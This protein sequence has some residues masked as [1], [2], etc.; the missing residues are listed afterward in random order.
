MDD[1]ESGIKLHR[2]GGRRRTK[3]T[4]KIGVSRATSDWLDLALHSEE[5]GED[6]SP[7]RSHHKGKRSSSKVR[8]GSTIFR[9]VDPHA[10]GQ[11][12]KGS[13]VNRYQAALRRYA[14][15]FKV[16]NGRAPN[17]DED[18]RPVRRTRTLV[19]DSGA[20]AA[21]PEASSSA[22]PHGKTVAAKWLSSSMLVASSDESPDSPVASKAAPKTNAVTAFQRVAQPNNSARKVSN[23]QLN[24]L[25]S[26][27]EARDEAQKAERKPASARDRIRNW[28]EQPAVEMGIIGVV[29]AYG[30]FV[31]VDIAVGK[32]ALGW[33]RDVGALIV[34]GFFLS[35]F[36]IELAVKVVV[37]GPASYC[38]SAL[39]VVD[40]FAIVLCATLYLLGDLL[41]VFGSSGDDDEEDGN[42]LGAFLVL[43]RVVRVFRLAAVMLRTLNASQSVGQKGGQRSASAGRRGSFQHR[44]TGD[45]LVAELE[46]EL[47][48]YRGTRGARAWEQHRREQAQIRFSPSKGLT[49]KAKSFFEQAPPKL[50][51]LLTSDFS[52]L[53]ELFKAL[54]QDGDGMLLA[55]E[56][57]PGLIQLGLSEET[58][59]ALFDAL[60][61]SNDGE[62][63]VAELFRAGA[64]LRTR[65]APSDNIT[66]Q[67]RNADPRSSPPVL[68]QQRSATASIALR[69]KHAAKRGF[70]GCEQKLRTGAKWWLHERWTESSEQSVAWNSQGGTFSEIDR[71]NDELTLRMPL[72]YDFEPGKVSLFEQFDGSGALLETR[73]E[74][75]LKLID[76]TQADV[77]NMI[78]KLIEIESAQPREAK[79]RHEEIITYR[80]YLR[81]LSR[82]LPAARLRVEPF[83]NDS[84]ERSGWQAIRRSPEL[85]ARVTRAARRLLIGFG[86]NLLVRMV[87]IAFCY[88]P[89]NGESA[90]TRR[91]DCER[92]FAI[93]TTTADINDVFNTEQKAALDSGDDYAHL[94]PTSGCDSSDPSLQPFYAS[95]VAPL[96]GV[97]TIVCFSSSLFRG[98]T[99]PT[100]LQQLLT[101]PRVLIIMLQAITRAG[102]VTSNMTRFPV[103]YK[104][105]GITGVGT[106]LF[107]A[108]LLD[109]L[110][111]PCAVVLF[112]LM[113]CL[114]VTAPRMRC[115][116]ALLLL[117]LLMESVAYSQASELA[118]V[119]EYRAD[120]GASV[121]VGLETGL[122]A[123]MLGAIISSVLK[124]RQLTFVK[125]P[126]G[127]M[128][129]VLF[130]A[131]SQKLEKQQRAQARKAF[132]E[133]DK[134]K[135]L[136]C[137][138]CAR[139]SSSTRR[140]S[141]PTCK[142]EASTVP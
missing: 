60:D 38:S 25:R 123:M 138:S 122:L 62:V 130:E 105:Y 39:N 16:E 77:T 8:T 80:T 135:K 11:E 116:L 26:S 74:S 66:Q 83:L 94:F 23:A 102:L 112:V 110:L 31:F 2:A 82:T 131:G 67:R 28:F 137:G 118:S 32:L 133:L 111:L 129:L 100:A 56:L 84:V 36:L 34:D 40:A 42:N 97:F 71:E 59:K 89:L 79:E 124:P 78:Q 119:L 63:E 13:K 50:V 125:L 98:N 57:L 43:L 88:L 18:W 54:D 93:G 5:D 70:A 47:P 58:S 87:V 37:Y 1:E 49:E 109:C 134:E 21:D 29:L 61:E 73:V 48:G 92:F 113:D 6:P 52:T 33:W 117:F 14:Y 35:F 75:L 104:V 3:R 22:E 107:L 141:S 24:S 10:A 51:D 7:D 12:P 30:L 20:P 45:D 44:K 85:E 76:L 65:A 139:L 17:S 106:T 81:S 136:V 15:A 95:C 127:L 55:A 27:K 69:R 142:V 90:T 115:V 108:K 86:S 121:I 103:A 101:D 46:A 53:L 126:T 64:Y 4:A 128:G 114:I 96:L 41:G 91:L 132:S 140:L 9:P 99:N 72:P 120:K 68:D 19:M